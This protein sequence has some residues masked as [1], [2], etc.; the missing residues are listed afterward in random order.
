MMKSVDKE[1]TVKFN[2]NNYVRV[3]LTPYGLSIL[4][5]QHNELA[6]KF[7]KIREFM[8]PKM[9]DGWCRFQLWSLMQTFGPSI[10]IGMN[11][12]P[13]ETEIEIEE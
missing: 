9:V 10:S 7:P 5:Q 13:F 12:V 3:K 1:D 8:P 6:A 2:I 4:E 11:N